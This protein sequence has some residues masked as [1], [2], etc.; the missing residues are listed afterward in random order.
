MSVSLQ[1]PPRD[2]YRFDQQAG[3]HGIALL[4]E[5]SHPPPPTAGVLRRI[6]PGSLINFFAVSEGFDASQGELK[7]GIRLPLPYALNGNTYLPQTILAQG[8]SHEPELL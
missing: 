1:Y 3:H 4:A 5:R 7:A 8:W 6:Q 2:L